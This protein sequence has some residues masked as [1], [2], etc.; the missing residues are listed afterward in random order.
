[1]NL[2]LAQRVEF[3]PDHYRMLGS[4]E[5]DAD[6]VALQEIAFIFD[7]LC[8]SGLA[9]NIHDGAI[10]LGKDCFNRLWEELDRRGAT[11]FVHIYH[12]R[13]P[14]NEKVV[15]TGNDLVYEYTFDT[16]RAVM[17]FM[18]LHKVTRWPHIRGAM[19]HAGGAIPFLAHRM[20][21][22]ALGCIHQGQEEILS[23]LRSFYYDLTLNGCDINYDFM[24]GF[25]GVNYLVFDSD[26]PSY[27]ESILKD[28]P[29]AICSSSVFT[30]EKKQKVLYGNLERL[31]L[32]P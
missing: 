18:F 29:E 15:F 1:M 3:C 6:S 19:P 27:N 5:Y 28:S 7:K 23:V 10:Y 12:N 30:E 16:T 4:I 32:E 14:D 21:L 20:S 11:V 13:A 17:D 25:V 24:K 8:V 9:L 26:H 22:W 2:L 31:L